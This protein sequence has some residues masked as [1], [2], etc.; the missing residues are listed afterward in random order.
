V[1]S[2]F[3]LFCAMLAWILGDTV[4]AVGAEYYLDPVKGNAANAGTRDA[5]WGSLETVAAAEKNFAAGDVLILL[6]GHHGSP[7]IHGGNPGM[8]TIRPEAG[9]RVTVTNLVIHAGRFW[10]VE[11][12]EISPETASK[13]RPGNLM[14]VEGSDMVIRGC[15]FY[16]ARDV[17]GWTKEDWDKRTCNGIALHGPRHL[18]EN[19]RFQNVRFAISVMRDATHVTVRGNL[20]MNFCG[21]GIRALGDYGLY[22]GNVVK[23]L[24]LVNTNH[25]DALQSWSQTDAGVG[26]G[27]VRGVTVRGNYFLGYDSPEK[28]FRGPLQ[29]IGCFD[30]FFEDWVVE[31]NVIITNSWHG[32]AF[33]G[34][35]NCR[36][37][38]N[39]VADLKTT[40]K[41]VAW[42][43]IAAHKN[44]TPST[45]NLVRNNL[46]G[47]LVLDR[48]S[49]QA[50]HNL[51]APNARSFFPGWASGDLRLT[52]RSAAVD[53]GTFDGAPT[54]DIRGAPRSYPG[55]RACDLGAYEL[56][57][58]DQIE[59]GS[60]PWEPRLQV[61]PMPGGPAP[62]QTDAESRTH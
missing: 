35:R 47:R 52:A 58:P 41:A 22:E 23:N 53:A 7:V 26:K 40:D 61:P 54:S 18:L 11:G 2:T 1:K 13:P 17:S 16:T 38:N 5:P 28:P 21:D 45:G 15:L 42:I 30:G 46:T 8:V 32:I 33:Y 3:S 57:A 60:L 24:Y 19:N 29:G 25:P 31:N 62:S 37:V 14:K 59:P 55:N 20:I 43:K 9:A 4:A 6:A 39:T 36:I 56:G 27:V 10:T 34:A 50:D 48:G 44:K 49:A 12:L 51:R